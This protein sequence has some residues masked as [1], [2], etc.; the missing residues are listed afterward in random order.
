MR[1]KIVLVVALLAVSL[2]CGRT[3][4]SS[5]IGTWVF[6]RIQIVYI[7]SQKLYISM[8]IIIVS[9]SWTWMFNRNRTVGFEVWIFNRNSACVCA[10]VLARAWMCVRFMYFFLVYSIRDAFVWSE[11][12]LNPKCMVIKVTRDISK[13][14][15]NA[16]CICLKAILVSLL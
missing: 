2:C 15:L 6:C 10:C 3:R 7:R 12:K 13:H 16:Q 14:R 1:L 4:K 11:L 9:I 8:N 5:V